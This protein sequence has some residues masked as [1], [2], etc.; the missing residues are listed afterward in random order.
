M[1]REERQLAST[2]SLQLTELFY[3]LDLFLA[4]DDVCRPLVFWG[5]S[6]YIITFDAEVFGGDEPFE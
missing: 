6:Y 4:D 2:S 3:I 1:N 5:S